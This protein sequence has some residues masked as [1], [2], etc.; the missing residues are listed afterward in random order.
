MNMAKQ[1]PTNRLSGCT[2]PYLL[3]HASN[4]V[5]W[6]P[7]DDTAIELAQKIDRPILVSIG[8]AACHWCH[9]MEH[10]S[11]DDK[12]TADLMNERLVCIKVDREERPDVDALYMAACQVMTGQGGWPLNAFL[13]PHT[14]KPFFAGTYFP[15]TQGYGRPSWSQ[16]VTVLSD[17]WR[18]KRDDILQN[19]EQI[20]LHLNQM[21]AAGE[22]SQD[23]LLELI[24]FVT[25]N[26]VQHSLNIFDSE[27]GGFGGAPKFPHPMELDALLRNGSENAN[28][29]VELSLNCM[30]ERGLF[31]HL[32]GGFHRYC[33]D[34]AWA[35]PHFEK[36]LYDNALLL[37]IYARAIRQGVGD[38]SAHQRVI[39]LTLEWL[40][41]EML[42]ERGGVWSTLDADSD[43]GTG[44][45]EEGVFY[46]WSPA[47]V[48]SA[49]GA[50]KSSLA[51][52]RWTVTESGN[53][54][55]S[56][57]SVLAISNVE[58]LT[59]DVEEELRLALLE[60]REDRIRPG[61][62]DKVLTTWNGM[63]LVA[64]CELQDE[65][66]NSV[67]EHVVRGLLQRSTNSDGSVLR[68][69][70]GHTDG[71]IGFLDDYAWSALGLLKW[72]LLT[73]DI[74]C[75]ER[76]I[77]ITD[78][79]I[80]DFSDPEGGFWLSTAEHGK[81]PVR[82]RCEKDSA[83][84]GSSAVVVRLLANLLGAFPADKNAH[85]WKSH[86]TGTIS[87][88]G[89]SL[90]QRGPAYWSLLNSASELLNPWSVW[91]IHH[92]GTEPDEVS[93]LRANA[94]DCQLVIS[95]E[96]VHDSK[97]RGDGQWMAWQCEGMTCK[98]PTTNSS[99][100]IW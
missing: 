33:V 78:R 96:S 62:D 72:G 44:H 100:L 75:I 86:A 47:Q 15:P 25:D 53:F 26:S 71:G 92:D 76:S 65:R 79:L 94:G 39:R 73:D 23:D 87:R 74:T 45:K 35:V 36:M 18:D 95:S 69:W 63:L 4:P 21:S 89:D 17:A 97:D 49:L 24:S 2:S 27:Y 16:L 98:S 77:A 11:F 83:V 88:L 57:S 81:L 82:Q 29:A 60:N 9:V 91:H 42:D 51:C 28:Q 90:K 61:T 80:K 37:P 13:D 67:G 8:Y 93:L 34:A 55:N 10:E 38:K 22:S 43:D 20:T 70:R 40:E 1:E 31:D 48:K 68:S 41:R 32:G 52:E 54:E 3:Q 59:P 64:L 99:D 7:W 46:V 19:A 50:K 58:A 14:L 5:A 56:G 85:T 30:A 66:A 84:P 6:Q 12:E